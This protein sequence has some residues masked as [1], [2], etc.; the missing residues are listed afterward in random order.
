[1]RSRKPPITLAG[2]LVPL[3]MGCGSKDESRGLLASGGSLVRI[4]EIQASGNSEFVDE[5]GDY[6]D[7]IELYNGGKHDAPL[8]GYF[9]TDNPDRPFKHMLLPEVVVP[10][11][12]FLVLFADD[13]SRTKLELLPDPWLHLPFKLSG[14]GESVYLRDPDGDLV[15][16]I[17]YGP[18]PYYLTPL[19]SGPPQGTCRD[20]DYACAYSY[21]RFPD[22]SGAF[23]WCEPPTP[24]KSN[25]SACEP[26][27]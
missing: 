19:T 14:L 23:A 1:M 3:L 8:G 15:D 22:G 21:A 5:A 7:W 6:D 17:D 13:P 18:I 11:G 16:G 27:P 24:E 26:P 10:A 2:I 4:N 9:I 12:G 20:P 25:E